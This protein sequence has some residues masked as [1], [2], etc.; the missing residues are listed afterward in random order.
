MVD[1]HLHTTFSDGQY[2]PAQI[3]ALAAV[4]GV[5]VLAI[6]DHDTIA[7]LPEA[8]QAAAENHIT[9]IPG[10]EIST[11]LHQDLHM[12]GYYI[13]P[14]SPSLRA[15][16]RQLAQDRRQREAR[17]YA[18]LAGRGVP[19][20]PEQVN[21]YVTEG[22]VGRPH[23]ARAM[24]AA[25]Y[26]QTV[27]E[28]FDKHLAV[29]EFYALERPKP[30]P[31]EAIAMIIQAGG[32]PVLAHPSLLNFSDTNLDNLLCRLT[33]AGLK[34]L[35]CHYSLHAPAQTAFYCHLAQKHGLLITGGSDFHGEAVKPAIQIGV[36]ISHANDCGKSALFTD[37]S[38]AQKLRSAAQSR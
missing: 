33:T 38:I 27:Q 4:A 24:V 29:P 9:L 32:V 36:G 28:A 14:E 20:T 16:C 23:F 22:L 7:G 21:R 35:E 30:T 15:F 18:F 34:G 8:T 31:E 26:V 5:T 25:G 19:L 6:T 13:N 12:L 10:I 1:L 2:T 3:V 37:A 17:L 11:N